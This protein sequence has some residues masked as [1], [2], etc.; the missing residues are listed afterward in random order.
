MMTIKEAAERVSIS[1]STI[2]YYDDQG[3]LPFIE[4]DQN[5]YRLFK[6]EDLFWLELISCMRATGM[7]VETLRQV[8]HLHMRGEETLGERIKI[9][10]EHQETLR[11][12]QQDIY[13]A[14]EKLQIKMNM[15]KGPSV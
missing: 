10:E 2:R 11:K 13:I 15:L 3:L 1:P 6:E 8:A 4:R 7:S 14:L 5:G 12:Q 9:F